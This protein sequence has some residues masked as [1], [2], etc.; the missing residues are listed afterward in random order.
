V[1]SLSMKQPPTT[2]GMQVPDAL[3]APDWHS[4]VLLVVQPASPSLK[5]HLPCEQVPYWH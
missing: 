3:H 1:Q 5:P 2:L 4:A